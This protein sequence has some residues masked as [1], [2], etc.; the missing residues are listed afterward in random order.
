MRDLSLDA[1]M[2]EAIPESQTRTKF[3]NFHL[4]KGPNRGKDLIFCLVGSPRL[5][6]RDI[7]ENARAA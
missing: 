1:P 6:S 4:D 5:A 7:P 2:R 3:S